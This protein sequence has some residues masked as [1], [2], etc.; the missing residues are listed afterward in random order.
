MNTV[1]FIVYA[2][3]LSDTQLLDLYNDKH[4][5]YCRLLDIGGVKNARRLYREL[6]TLESIMQM[7]NIS[8]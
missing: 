2:Q 6:Y 7:R 8:Y 3:G 4:Y 5:K 1:Q